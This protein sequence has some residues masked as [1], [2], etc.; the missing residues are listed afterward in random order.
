MSFTRREL[1]EL[2]KK[3]S[4]AKVKERLLLVLRVKGDSI[5]PARVVKDIHRSRPWASY[6]LERFANEG[7]EGLKEK[8]RSG[9]P[10]KLSPEIIHHIKKELSDSKQGWTTKQVEDLIFKKGG[11]LKYHYTHIYRILHKWGFKLKIPR[12]MHIKTA[13]KEEKENFKK[14]LERS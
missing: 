8:H 11:G 5:I 12:K 6:W 1:V 3:E 4:N 10:P 7:V 14:K 9:R 13:S 2:Y